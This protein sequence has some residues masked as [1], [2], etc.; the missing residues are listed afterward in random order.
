MKRIV[1]YLR[2][3][4]LAFIVLILVV[5][6]GGILFTRTERFQVL[7]RD[8]L[9]SALNAS[10][11]GDVS[12]ERIEGSIWRNVTLHNLTIQHQG[13][14]IL[15]VPHLTVQYS[16]LPLLR[17]RMEVSRVEAV[18]PV[19]RLK[20]DAAGKWNI[21]EALASETAQP[22]AAPTA[23]GGLAVH[24]D[25]VAVQGARIDV[26]LARRLSRRTTSPRPPW[27]RKL[28][29]CRLASKSRSAA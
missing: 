10:F 6:V 4:A 2:W 23:E 19:V 16:L 8:Q 11:R 17:G 7:L 22:E 27:M 13:A 9:V 21:L 20:Q 29:C 1:S 25:T 5:V 3:I 26:T 18:E 12:V 14:D 28:G 15:Y 24:L